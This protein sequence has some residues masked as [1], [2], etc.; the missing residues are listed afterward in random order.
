MKNQA[1]KLIQMVQEK[2]PQKTSTKFIA[3]TSGKGGV[4][5]TTI[6]ANLG[7]TLASMG[8]KVAL[9]DAD[10]G[11]ANLDVA[12]GVKT[13]ATLL[14]VLRGEKKLEE[15]I[16]EVEQNLFL[17]PGESGDEIL[18][19]ADERL[20]DKFLEDAKVFSVFDFVIVDTG[21]G[22]SKSVQSFLLASD[23][24][25]IVTA[26]EPS[27]I[28]DAYAL[29][30][31]ISQ[32]AQDLRLLIN[33]VSGEKEA[34][35]VFAKISAVASKNLASDL[36]LSLIGALNKDANV[37]KAIK[38]RFLFAKEFGLSVPS[39]QLKNVAQNI[40]ND[41]EHN[42]LLKEEDGFVRFFRKLVSQF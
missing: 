11:L 12:L 13:N 7:Y 14:N 9:F 2:S 15:I 36:K 8:K 29:I 27:A 19:F 34:N 4:G 40:I 16:V 37:E 25:I 18:N 23:K 10:I 21:A 30:K 6:S 1:D 24:I 35:S 22:I 20:I 39:K 3:I 38:K 31:V 33:Q 5:K 17:I 42:M 28:T 32:K 26:P 41:L